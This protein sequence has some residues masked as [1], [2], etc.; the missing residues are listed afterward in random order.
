[1]ISQVQRINTALNEKEYKGISNSH[2]YITDEIGSKVIQNI[3][4]GT[5]L[6]LSSMLPGIRILGDFRAEYELRSLICYLGVH[7][8]ITISEFQMHGATH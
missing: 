1:M 5:D 2:L 6:Y 8:K 7:D 3:Y 4:I